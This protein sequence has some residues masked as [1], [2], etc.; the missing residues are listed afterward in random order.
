MAIGWAL[1]P[2]WQLVRYDVGL[3]EAWLGLSGGLVAWLLHSLLEVPFSDM[4]S[5]LAFWIL[6]GLGVSVAQQYR[7]WRLLPECE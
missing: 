4:S 3:W 7:G 2:G 6:V 1:S 5:Q